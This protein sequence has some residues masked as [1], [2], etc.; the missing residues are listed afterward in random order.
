MSEAK[1]Q[2]T[3]ANLPFDNDQLQNLCMCSLMTRTE[4]SLPNLSY[5]ITWLISI[6]SK[7]IKIV[8]VVVVFVVVIFVQ[9]R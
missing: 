6:V 7:P 1:E 8:V 3:I 2:E 9:K 5:C 4:N